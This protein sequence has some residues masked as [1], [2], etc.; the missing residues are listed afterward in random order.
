MSQTIMPLGENV[1]VTPQEMDAMTKSGIVLPE[2]ANKERPQIGT[3][4]AVGDKVESLTVGDKV[5][6]K[7]YGPTEFELN[8]TEYLILEEEDVLGKIV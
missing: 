1:V 5:I 3:V 7:K 4:T 8:G 2:T 6:F